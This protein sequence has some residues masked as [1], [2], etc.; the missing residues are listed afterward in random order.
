MARA[1]VPAA[2]F[3]AA[4]IAYVLTGPRHIT[5]AHGGFD[6]GD[7]L[8]A[9]AV[10]GVPHPP[11]YPFYTM[12]LGGAL[13]VLPFADAAFRGH[14]LSMMLAAG[15]A[16]LTADMGRR[17]T[18]SAAAGI[19]GALAM[20]F[21]LPVW[22]QALITEVYALELFL[23]ALAWWALYR[24][25]AERL[26]PG[27][28]GLL[29]G[30]GLTHRPT[31]LA[32]IAG[33]GLVLLARRE[34]LTRRS[35]IA[36]A[37]GF[38]VGL[39]PLLYLPLAAS[40]K[41]PILWGEPSMPAGFWD[42]IT[43]KMYGGHVLG[44]PVSAWGER[45]LAW[46]GQLILSGAALITLAV[47]GRAHPK[48]AIFWGMALDGAARLIFAFT[49]DRRDAA[50]NM[51][52]P[53]FFLGVWVC[54]AAAWLIQR[55]AFGAWTAAVMLVIPAA[56]LVGNWA[57]VDVRTDSEARDFG[58]SALESV[59]PDALILT[60]QD[61]RTFT[62]HYFVHAIGLRQ[63][64]TVADVRLLMWPWYAERMALAGANPNIRSVDNM[65]LSVA[66]VQDRPVYTDAQPA[67]LPPCLRAESAGVLWKLVDSCKEG[68]E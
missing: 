61:A 22:T 54:A 65:V 38:A 42:L 11:G 35:W 18:R 68:V 45:A 50:V 26:N 8:A 40:A 67:A 31:A 12:L 46:S 58:R 9:A 44:L 1:F 30:L 53:A 52:A 41:P 63:D 27:W 29:L 33:I 15:A 13:R 16:A 28:L 37:A 36:L 4:L 20:A 66:A 32:S 6:G 64:V 60:T 14:F 62:L 47:Y 17:L 19:V 7:L 23:L 39:L 10:S 2:A 5:W 57:R 59:D 34:R 51:A 55:R 25:R 56:L 21:W 43:A 49:Y 3:F 24:W 48:G